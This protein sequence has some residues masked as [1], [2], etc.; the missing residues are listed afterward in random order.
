[1]LQKVLSQLF[2]ISLMVATSVLVLMYGW[3]LHPQSWW[4][5]IG[6][7][8][9]VNTALRLLADRIEEDGKKPVERE[10]R[11]AQK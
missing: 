9:F 4:W 5:I 8:V 7:G 6:G 2:L 1:M 10:V 11:T 3:G